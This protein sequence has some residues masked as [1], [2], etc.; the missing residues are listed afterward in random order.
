MQ[1]M[2]VTVWLGVGY[3]R[4]DVACPETLSDIKPVLI[5]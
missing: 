3:A 5:P 4:N 1:E 2:S